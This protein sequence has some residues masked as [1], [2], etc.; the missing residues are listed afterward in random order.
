[1]AYQKVNADQRASGH[2]QY[3]DNDDLQA[4]AL[5]LEWDME[6]ELEE[7]GFDQF[8]L[9]TAENQNLGHSET[10]D[11]NL[12]SIQPATSPKGRFQRLQEESDYVAHY[13]RSAPKSNRCHILKILCTATILFIFGILIGYYAHTNCPSDA[14]TSGTIDPQLYQEILKTIQAEDIKKSFR[15]LVE[16]YKNEDDMEISKRIKTHWTSLGLE[17]VQLANYSVLLNLPG[18]SPSTVTVS[19]SGQ[20]FHPDGQPCSEEARKDSSQDPLYSYAAYSAKGTLEAEVID[21]SYGTADDLKMIKKV[22]NITNQIALLKLGKLP[23]LYKISLLEKAGFGGVLL[24]IDPCDLPKTANINYDNFMVT[25]NPGGD[26]STPGYPSVDGS[27]RQSQSNLTSLLV[28]PISASL[29]AKLISSPTTRSKSNICSPLE[30][31]NN[32]IRIVSMQIQTVTKFKTVTNVIGYLKGMASPDRYIIVGSHH[33]S[34]YSYNGQEWASST[35]IIT[36]FIRALMLRV[37]KGWRPDRTIVF[38]SWGGTTWG[39]I[40]S[41]EWGE[42]FK[43]VLQKD[44]VAYISLH[45]P[46]RGNSSLHPVASPSLQQLVVEKNKFNCTRRAQ[47]PETNVSSVQIQGDA[48]YFINH[49][50]VPTVQFAYEDIKALEGPSFLSEAVFPKDATKIEEMDPFFN[51]HETISKLSGEVILQI[52]NEPVLP[53]NAL[54]IALEVQNS[55]KGDHPNAQHLLALASGLRESAE[56]FQS[57]EMRPANDP[58]ERAPVRVR[59]LNDILQDME[60]SFLV[61]QVPP[62]FYRNILYHTDEK[63]SQFS[64]LMEAWEHCKSLTSNETLQETL[65]DV[66]NSINSAQVYFKA[67]LDVFESVLVGKN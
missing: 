30:L 21:V 29:V 50:G 4:T 23:L 5:D 43:K 1:M 27:F 12:D 17:D 8:Q 14:T 53:F 16:L 46:I 62:G 49:L 36:A 11:L 51:L 20:C 38:C 61:Q 24:Y 37:K 6:K 33:Y 56:L 15:N 9:D 7:P 19:S 35:A 34:G 55:L 2:S 40:G 10:A 65:S 39:N 57:D 32:E 66:L 64:I 31:P 54:D 42:D 47:C 22:K 44:V 18:P 67:G 41:Y 58:K 3:L 52:A 48:D 45:S 26:P 13:G 25:L 63:T 60:K 28:Q 59:M